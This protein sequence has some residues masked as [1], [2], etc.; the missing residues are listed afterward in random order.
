MMSNNFDFNELRAQVLE[1][2]KAGKRLF[3]KE[4][5]FAPL[6]ENTSMLPLKRRWRITLAAVFL[7]RQ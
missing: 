7:P 5:A 6:L 2:T 1:E 4:G 3:G